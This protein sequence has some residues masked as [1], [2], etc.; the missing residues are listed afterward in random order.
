VVTI[1]GNSKQAEWGGKLLATANLQYGFWKRMPE[2]T[3]I[4]KKAKSMPGFKVC[5]STVSL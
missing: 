5:V 4:Y 2:R 3:F 1:F